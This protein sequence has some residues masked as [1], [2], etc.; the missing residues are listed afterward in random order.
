MR[1]GKDGIANYRHESKVETPNVAPECRGG[2][3]TDWGATE[4]G[5]R[6]KISCFILAWLHPDESSVEKERQKSSHP[7]RDA[8]LWGAHILPMLRIP[9]GMR[10]CNNVRVKHYKAFH[11]KMYPLYLRLL[12]LFSP[13]P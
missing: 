3:P 11:E 6:C 5:K 13:V 7:V 12:T 8:D 2:G 1:T 10:E 9:Y 4:V